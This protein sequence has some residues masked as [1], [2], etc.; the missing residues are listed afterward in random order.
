MRNR[1]AVVSC[2]FS[3]LTCAAFAGPDWDEGGTDAGPLPASGQ[4]ISSTSGAGITRISGRTSAALVGIPDLVDLYLMKTGALFSLPSFRIDMNM[5]P[6][7][8]GSPIWNARLSIFKK[9]TIVC[10]GVETVIARP[11]ATVV[12]FNASTAYP[13]LYGNAQ[14]LST[15]AT[16]L[17]QHLSANTEYFVAVS[18][19]DFSA[20]G[21][22]DTAAD[23][24]FSGVGSP[25]E[26]F[27]SAVSA[28]TP[29]IYPPALSS[30]ATTG[31][32]TE[33][34]DSFT[35]PPATFIGPYAMPTVATWTLPASNCGATFPISGAPV[36][37]DFNLTYAPNI[38]ALGETISCAGTKVVHREFFYKW[39]PNCSGEATVTTCGLAPG[40][41][42]G[43]QVFPID[44]CAADA[45]AAAGGCALA[46]NDNCSASISGG[47][48]VS[49]PAEAGMEY[50]VRLMALNA[51]T[52]LTGTIKFLCV[53][54]LGGCCVANPGQTCCSD[55][56]CCESVCNIDPYCCATE[57]DQVCANEAGTYCTCCG[58]TPAPSGDINGDGIVDGSDLSILM[59]QWGTAG[60]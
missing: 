40:F 32:I 15:P 2:V 53:A 38:S 3:A 29:G 37:N 54:E 57:W 26:L 16:Y 58:G 36:L 7:G 42:C 35:S 44:A 31:K 8:T 18:G 50:L 10:D 21:T 24:Y 23:C 20:W 59:S 55:A 27:D 46:C 11:V 25:K 49:F 47:S 17:Y 43:I 34:R 13:V 56:G 6:G 19:A 41:D 33:W 52:S 30:Y 60:P 48:S 12:R 45:C 22:T 5:L 4:T 28:S 9:V 51:S 1:V 39:T 14:V